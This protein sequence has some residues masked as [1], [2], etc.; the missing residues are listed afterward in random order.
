MR[1]DLLADLLEAAKIGTPGT[2]IFE[3]EMPADA[4]AGVLLRLPILGV[5]I[6]WEIPGYLKGQV[7]AIVRAQKVA[8]GDALARKVSEALTFTDR[9]FTDDKGVE[10]MFVNYLRPRTL[11]IIYP[12]SDGNG[13]EWSINLDA[14]YVLR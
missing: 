3:D 11:P 4:R 8:T 13:K 1:I 6:D 7:Q 14:C 10:V 12:R 5:P 2:S 9:S